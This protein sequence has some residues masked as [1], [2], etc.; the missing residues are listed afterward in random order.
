MTEINLEYLLDLITQAGKNDSMDTI[1][2]GVDEYLT[3]V[4][5]AG[6]QVFLKFSSEQAQSLL[7]M[8]MSKAALETLTIDDPRA[9][10]MFALLRDEMFISYIIQVM[11]V[12][13]GLVI[14][15]ELR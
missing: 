12:T 13:A 8:I 11:K 15:E 4:S 3:N 7:S 2:D 9:V 6:G 5:N 10:M 1:P 14:L